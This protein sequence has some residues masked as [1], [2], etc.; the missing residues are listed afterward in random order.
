MVS[1]V[2]LKIQEYFTVRLLSLC[3]IKNRTKLE[4]GEN[5]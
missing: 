5:N 2:N 4:V 1:F 3:R